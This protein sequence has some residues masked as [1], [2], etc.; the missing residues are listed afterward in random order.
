MLE[1]QN[2]F[3]VSN[4]IICVY[5]LIFAM[6]REK[7]PRVNGILSGKSNIPINRTAVRNQ[8]RIL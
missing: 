6:T 2:K 5:P 8:G 7:K 4:S 1:K 3:K